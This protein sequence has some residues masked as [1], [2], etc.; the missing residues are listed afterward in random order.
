MRYLDRIRQGLK[1]IGGHM[2]SNPTIGSNPNGLL[3]GER[4][5]IYPNRVDNFDE[6]M[7]EEQIFSHAFT[8]F[9]SLSYTVNLKV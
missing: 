1:V 9:R 4:K 7:L 5:L 8:D 3:S 2:G 6:L